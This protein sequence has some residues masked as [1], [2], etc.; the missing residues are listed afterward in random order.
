MA[1]TT[2]PYRTTPA[3]KAAGRVVRDLRRRKGLSPEALSYA[4]LSAGHGH[5]STRTLRRLEQGVTPRLRIQ[6]AVATFLE[7]EVPQI[8]PER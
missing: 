3:G 8:W 4:I 2:S 1:A 6:F 5:V 7:R